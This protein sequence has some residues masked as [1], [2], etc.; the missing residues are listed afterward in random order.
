[1]ICASGDHELLLNS[2]SQSS[3][4]IG[5]LACEKVVG[6]VRKNSP[7]RDYGSGGCGCCC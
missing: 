2:L 6:Q 7:S 3:A 1:M 5:S 4:S